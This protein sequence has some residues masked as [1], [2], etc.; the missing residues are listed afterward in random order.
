[1]T[2]SLRRMAFSFRARL[3]ALVF[4]SR[5]PFSRRKF[6]NVGSGR[7]LWPSWWCLDEIQSLG[8]TGMTFN[9]TC[10]FPVPTDSVEIV[11][12]SHFLE[13]I[14]D[15]TVEIRLAMTQKYNV[16]F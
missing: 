12:S 1:M 8:T 3:A 10:S 2:D 5:V 9:P 16:E 4:L 14:D 6:L 13:H 11:Y 15:A 7:R